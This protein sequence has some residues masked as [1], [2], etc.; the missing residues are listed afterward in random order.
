MTVSL[1]LVQYVAT[2]RLKIESLGGSLLTFYPL[3]NASRSFSLLDLT[4]P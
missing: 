2:Q 1:P 3:I 4:F